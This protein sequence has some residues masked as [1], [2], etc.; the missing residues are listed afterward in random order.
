[1]EY[2]RTDEIT[3]KQDWLALS[4]YDYFFAEKT[5]FSFTY[6]AKQEKFAGLNLRQFVGPGIGHQFYEGKPTDLLT[7]LGIFALDEDF[8][9]QS[10]NSYW[11]PAWKLK[12]EHEL[13]DGKLTFYH[14]HY[15][16]LSAE[17]TDKYLWHSWTGLRF[18]IVDK[19]VGSLEYEVDYDS[20]PALD[21]EKSDT[22]VR[23]KIGYEW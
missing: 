21:A 2:D 10:D 9:E 3:T 7:E 20:H 12:F 5:Y 6:G 11:G 16:V 1:M 13:I 19:L 15:A 18:P 14:N 23:L 17:D 4:K 8:V 22:T